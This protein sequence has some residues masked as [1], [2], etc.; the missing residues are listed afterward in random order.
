MSQV[1]ELFVA[2]DAKM[3]GFNKGMD[4]VSS[5]L[6][7]VAKTVGAATVAIGA[8]VA[9]AG[10]S[11]MAMATK[12]AGATDR[13]DKMSQKL[14]LS[15]ESFQQ[16]DY[17]LSQNGAS[18]DGLGQ[19]MKT[20]TNQVDELG[21]GG[22]VATDA[23]GELGMSYDDLS[24]LTQ[25]E[26][27]EKTVVA[28]QGIEDTT[29]RAALAN[30]LLGRS[31]QELAPLLNAGADSVEELKNRA[32]ELG[33]VLSDDAITAGVSFTDTMDSVKRMLGSVGSQIG[34]TLMPIIESFL[35][36][37]MSNMPTIQSVMGKVFDVIS[38]AVEIAFDVF[39]TYLLP[40]LKDLFAY[41]QAN[42][43]V[44][45]S[46]INTVFTAVFDIVKEVWDIFQNNLIPILKTLYDWVKPYFPLIGDIIKTAFDTVITILDGVVGAF[47]AVTGVIKDVL[48]WIDRFNNKKVNDKNVN[49]TTSTSQYGGVPSF[50]T[51]GVVPGPVGKPRLIEAHGGETILPTHKQGFSSG[52]GTANITVELD[53]RTLAK[54]IGQPLVD[55]IRVKTGLR[56]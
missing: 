20:L 34:V 50:D 13:V 29:K 56:I 23:F 52:G 36:W 26:I 16:W 40:V 35:Q 30:D 7:G 55:E 5:K 44:I 9:A 6:G 32:N 31:G 1:G 38:K 17:I 49:V 19:G 25:E 41:I 11:M 22:K 8:G 54:A 42:M 27:F 48:D 2:I 18:I 53:G 47:E 39:N 33:L 37:V 14:G 51:G 24:G 15:R 28:L 10:G 4:T 43:P 46:T 12:A 3:D 21:K 45:K